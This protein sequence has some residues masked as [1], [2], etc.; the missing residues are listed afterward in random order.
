MAP[1]LHHPRSSSPLCI[2]C[3]RLDHQH[4][5]RAVSVPWRAFP[6]P[7][8]RILLSE[9]DPLSKTT[10]L[11]TAGHQVDPGGV[12]GAY[13]SFTVITD[14]KKLQHLRDAKSLN[15]CQALFYTFPFYHHLPSR[16]PL[17]RLHAPD[18]RSESEPILPPALIVIPIQ[19]ELTKRICDATCTEPALQ[20]G[21][22]GKTYVPSSQRLT[23]LGSVHKVPCSGHPGSQRTL[24][25]LQARYWWPSMTEDVIMYFRSCS[26][27][28]MS[29]SPH[30]LPAGKLVA[31]SPACSPKT[32]V[33]H[34]SR[35]RLRPPNLEGHTCARGRRPFLQ[36]VQI[37][38]PERPTHCSRD[39]RESLSPCVPKLWSARG[40]CL[41]PGS[42]VHFTGMK[43]LL[44][45][46]RGHS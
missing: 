19:W 46:F 13:S 38:P 2:R 22:E 6:P 39:H 28:A 24:S 11:G 26:V 32:L 16:K 14:H 40:H 31:G 42:P 35:L 37:D 9:T 27:C 12:K 8:M 30:H 34:R 43:G 15:R 44:S 1:I 10:A 29:K 4:H 33:A 18:Q 41:R 21:P 36:G 23:L 7:S 5:G 45:A 3:R 25:L 17:S 20:D